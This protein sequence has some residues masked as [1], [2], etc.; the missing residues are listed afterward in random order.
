MTP[1]NEE[2][3]GASRPDPADE[4]R[5]LRER[6]E[7]AKSYL[8]VDDLRA[9]LAELESEIAEPDLWSDPERARK[10]NTDYGRTK[11]DL[12]LVEGLDR[13]LSDAEVLW[14]LALEEGE[15]AVAESSA[16]VADSVAAVGR[17][18]DD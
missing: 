17:A 5:N 18:L 8:R 7:A 16:E 4:L 9:R 12:D 2:A 6:L 3:R 13:R 11:S 14:S 10:V 1:P 15:E